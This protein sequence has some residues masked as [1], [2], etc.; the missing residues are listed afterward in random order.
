M[1]PIIRRLQAIIVLYS[2]NHALIEGV[3]RQCLINREPI[4]QALGTQSILAHNP[5]QCSVKANDHL[6]PTING[7]S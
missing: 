7:N 3:R 6:E 4:P 5:P 1:T 2:F